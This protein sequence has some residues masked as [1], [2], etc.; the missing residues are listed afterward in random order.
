MQNQSLPTSQG[1][2]AATGLPMPVVQTPAPGA[3]GGGM[4]MVPMQSPG[5]GASIS[6]GLLL[7]YLVQKT[8][9]ELNVLAEL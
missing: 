6:L 1:Q 8:Y 4:Q 5:G 3:Q 7:E 2:L 9:H